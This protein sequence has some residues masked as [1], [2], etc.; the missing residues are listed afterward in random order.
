MYIIKIVFKFCLL[1]EG[2]GKGKKLVLRVYISLWCSGKYKNFRPSYY[3]HTEASSRNS[4]TIFQTT[5]CSVGSRLVYI[6]LLSFCFFLP[7]LLPF[8]VILVLPSAQSSLSG[9]NQMCRISA[10]GTTAPQSWFLAPQTTQQTST[11][12]QLAAYW[13]SCC[14]DSPYSPATVEWIS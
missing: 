11:S 7:S 10:H 3:L 8:N 1:T 5:E 9:V 12:G 2:E 13:Q 14:S 4:V 6:D